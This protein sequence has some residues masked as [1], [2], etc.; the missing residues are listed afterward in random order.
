[1]ASVPTLACELLVLYVGVPGAIHARLLPRLPI[2][3]EESHSLLLV[4][5]EHAVFGQLLF[6]IGL[7][8]YFY[9]RGASR[10]AAKA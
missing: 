1:V 3:Y 10:L 4:S 9:S 8:R 2:L 7:G 6:T 5:I